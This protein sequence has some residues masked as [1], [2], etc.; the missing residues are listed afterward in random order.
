MSQPWRGSPYQGGAIN[1]SGSRAHFNSPAALWGDR[2]N[3]YTIDGCSIRKIVAATGEVTTFAGFAS[4]CSLVDG[5]RDVARF[6]SL[7]D[8]IVGDGASLYVIDGPVCPAGSR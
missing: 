4:P 6:R 7:A 5:P 3:L 2:G 8:F 1:G